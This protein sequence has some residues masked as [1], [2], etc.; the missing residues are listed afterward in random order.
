MT[1][2]ELW[3]ISRRARPDAAF[4]ERLA[5][6]FTPERAV[7]FAY[8]TTLRIAAA[9]CAFV[10]VLGGSTA[11]YAYASESV[12]PDHPLYPLRETVES[13]EESTALNAEAKTAVQR[14]F[15]ERRLKEIR[16]MRDRRLALAP[17]VITRLRDS[18]LRL[19]TTSTAEGVMAIDAWNALLQRRMR[20]LDKREA[21]RLQ[22]EADEK[23]NQIE[24]RIQTL[25]EK[26]RKLRPGSL[27]RK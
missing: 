5:S 6:R 26:A 16:I 18:M 24:K 7:R 10:L 11:S 9:A 23:F 12:L 4:V 8:R 13:L 17:R 20:T 14:K 19:E 21:A 2:Y 1:R 15:V 27:R 3:K 22:R 25:Q